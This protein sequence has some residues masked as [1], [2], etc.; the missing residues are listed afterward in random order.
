MKHMFVI[1]LVSAG[2]LRPACAEPAQPVAVPMQIADIVPE[3]SFEDDI[4]SVSRKIRS[5]TLVMQIKRVYARTFQNVDAGNFVEA[6]K[7]LD[8]A[9]AD[10]EMEDQKRAEMVGSRGMM[11][12]A[13]GDLTAARGDIDVG[14]KALEG[15]PLSSGQKTMLSNLK[16]LKGHILFQDGRVVEALRSED[17]AVAQDPKYG[18]PNVFRAR[19]LLKLG[20]Y[21]DAVDAFETAVRLDPTIIVKKRNVCDE[22]KASGK[23]PPSCAA[24]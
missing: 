2:L 24:V 13:A 11:E 18:M 19:F 10:Q 9:L 17:E 15:R 14:I 16:M 23:T 5:M 6:K 3:T 1:G 8:S 4:S 7:D 12:V 21:D 22:F 20:K